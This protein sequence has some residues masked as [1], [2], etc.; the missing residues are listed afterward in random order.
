MGGR[1]EHLSGIVMF[2]G[3]ATGSTLSF[4]VDFPKSLFPAWTFAVG[5]CR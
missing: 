3:R 5:C 2:N 1:W 4:K